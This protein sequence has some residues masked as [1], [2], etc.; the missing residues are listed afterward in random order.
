MGLC[1]TN[2][3][4]IL[5]YIPYNWPGLNETTG[6]Q[7][8]A[9][10]ECLRIFI[11]VPSTTSR[12]VSGHLVGLHGG[13]GARQCLGSEVGVRRS[14]YVCHGWMTVLIPLR[15]VS[16]AVAD[17]KL[18]ERLLMVCRTPQSKFPIT[19]GEI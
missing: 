17:V 3:W 18:V 10:D 15:H 4:N 1:V 13:D 14:P 19:R 9:A 11:L 8:R 5:Q 16:L 7:L 2:R 6:V 12:V